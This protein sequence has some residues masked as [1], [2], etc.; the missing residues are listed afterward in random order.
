MCLLHHPCK[1]VWCSHCGSSPH[2]NTW[3]SPK[4]RTW[5]FPCKINSQV[6]TRRRARLGYSM[7]RNLTLFTKQISTTRQWLDDGAT[8]PD[9]L[10]T[11]FLYLFFLHPVNEA[12]I[13][14][15]VLSKYKVKSRSVLRK[16]TYL[17]HLLPM[18]L[19]DTQ[20]ESQCY[21]NKAIKM[22]TVHTMNNTIKS[23]DTI[24]EQWYTGGIISPVNSGIQAV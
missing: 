8:K 22:T 17:F 21:K 24:K 13:L 9:W 12:F 6:K 7:R 10:N 19:L 16:I 2:H 14:N 11:V 15:S 20:G 18:F 1:A 23:N 3:S 5:W 4:S